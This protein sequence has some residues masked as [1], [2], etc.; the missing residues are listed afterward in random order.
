MA[1]VGEPTPRSRPDRTL[2]ALLIIVAVVI[3]ILGAYVLYR[4]ILSNR[5]E[6]RLEA[7]RAAGFP[8]TPEELDDWYPEPPVG[9]NA[10]YVFQKAFSKFALSLTKEDREAMPV[11]GRGELPAH[12]ESLPEEMRDRIAAH[13]QRNAEALELLCQAARMD[14]CRYPVDL[15]AGPWM[16][17]PHLSR[18]RQA[19]R[20]LRLQTVLAAEQN[21]PDQAEQAILASLGVG[22]SLARE[23]IFISNLVRIA[24]NSITRK[25]LEY[26]VGRTTFTDA[27]LLRMQQAFAAAEDPAAMARAL[28]GERCTGVAAFNMV[29]PVG[30]GAGIPPTFPL[31]ITGLLDMDEQW[32]LDIMGDYV[33]AAALPLEERQKA[34]EEIAKQ[35]QDIPKY[36]FFSRLLTPALVRA[37]DEDLKGIA[38][39]RCAVT[40]LVIERYRLAD[41]RLPDAL[42]DLVPKY[43]SGIPADPFDGNPLHYRKPDKGYIVYS[44]GWDG[45]DNG[46]VE[47][48]PEPSSGDIA[49]TV[50]R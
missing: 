45:K 32:Y 4:T 19:A 3:V 40:G 35:T 13:V 49:F 17:L 28:A 22:R 7:I 6:V 27:Q 5:V 34:S 31:R 43:L 1:D 16:L 42:S 9:E 26:A 11:F 46:G 48:P 20:L 24:C 44:I 23:P 25:S 8:A 47:N 38:R 37:F 15:T 39:L 12:G 21:D 30:G 36:C 50:W 2:R 29:I 18:L 41:G 33:E 10:A 14:Q